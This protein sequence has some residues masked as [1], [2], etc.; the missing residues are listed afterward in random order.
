MLEKPMNARSPL[1]LLHED[2]EILVVDKPSGLASQGGESVGVSLVEAVERDFGFRPWLVHRLDRETAGCIV[3]AKSREA[4][5]RWS[6]L[7]SGRAV[8]KV[9]RALCS[10]APGALSG[11]AGVYSDSLPEAGARGKDGAGTSASTSWRLIGRFG[12]SLRFSL[13]E[14][15]LGT[16][17]THQIRRHMAMHGH[18]ILAD[19]RY[20]DFAVNKELRKSSGLKRL[21]LWACRLELPGGIVLRS[22]MPGHFAEFLA[23]YPDAPDTEAG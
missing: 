3:V 8:R 4:A 11:T 23:R 16:G 19:D 7:I 21:M 2:D 17:R 15:E 12:P 10:G 6:A 13:L 20:G 18:P 22:A 14:L 9:Y 5:A 1:P